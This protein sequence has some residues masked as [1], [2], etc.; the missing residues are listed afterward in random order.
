MTEQKLTLF[1]KRV[2]L[3]PLAR[4]TETKGGIIIPDTA[5]IKYLRARVHAVGDEVTKMKEGDTVLYPA[6]IGDDVQ[7]GG[8]NLKLM[9]E[10]IITGRI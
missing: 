10:E 6:S 5:A 4:D 7:E 2:L 1:G 8:K 9:F 3:E